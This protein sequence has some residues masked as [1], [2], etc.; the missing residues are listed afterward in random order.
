MKT[1]S[2]EEILKEYTDQDLSGS[3]ILHNDDYHTFNEVIV[4]LMLAIECTKQKA[5]FFANEVH[6]KGQAKVYYGA[7]EN[8][9]NVS[10]VLED[11]QLKTTIEI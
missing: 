6:S 2:R 4:Q 9:L 3:V 8:C 5:E 10:S 1:L 7:L 11:I